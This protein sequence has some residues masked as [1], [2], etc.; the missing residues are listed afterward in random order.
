[1]KDPLFPVVRKLMAAN[2][3]CLGILDYWPGGGNDVYSDTLKSQ[4]L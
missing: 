4:S 3:Y 2:R 1:M